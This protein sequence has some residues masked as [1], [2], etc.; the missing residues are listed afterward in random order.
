MILIRAVGPT[1]IAPKGEPRL[2]KAV[3]QRYGQSVEDVAEAWRPFRT[4]VSVL[5]RASA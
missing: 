3:Q 1:D 2:D 5:M 4:W